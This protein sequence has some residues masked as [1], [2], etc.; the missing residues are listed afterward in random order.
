MIRPVAVGALLAL[1]GGGCGA[2]DMDGVRVASR[3]GALTIAAPA[4]WTTDYSYRMAS[5]PGEGVSVRSGGTERLR[6]YISVT[7]LEEAFG[8]DPTNRDLSTFRQVVTKVSGMALL[9]LGE[10]CKQEAIRPVDGAGFYGEMVVFGECAGS[11][12]FE[13]R[14]ILVDAARTTVAWLTVRDRDR[15]R[16]RSVAQL[17][18][19]NL[20]VSRDVIPEAV[21][22]DAVLAP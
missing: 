2:G 6:A 12:P 17:A 8:D 22:Q 7:A 4:G 3:S 14:T 15:E 1:V 11:W 19:D 10:G 16:A 20:R 21:D 18:L 9:A 13:V 5:I